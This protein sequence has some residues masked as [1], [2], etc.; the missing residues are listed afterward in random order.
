[1]F[2]N[3]R[4][5]DIAFVF[6]KKTNKSAFAI[7]ADKGDNTH[8]GEGSVALANAI[9]VK[10]IF[11]RRKHQIIAADASNGTIAYVLFKNTGTGKPLSIEEITAKAS[12]IPQSKIDEYLNCL[13]R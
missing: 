12:S 4:P 6:N 1:M 13:L 9:N 2:K 3:A 10:L 5:G 7:I 11:S 8:I